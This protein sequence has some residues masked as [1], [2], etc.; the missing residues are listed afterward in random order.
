MILLACVTWGLVQNLRASDQIRA[1]VLLQWFEGF[2]VSFTEHKTIRIDC[3]KL[4]SQSEN[5]KKTQWSIIQRQKNS[6]LSANPE[7]FPCGYGA[8]FRWGHSD[9]LCLDLLC[10]CIRVGKWRHKISP[11]SA[12][13][14]N[15]HITAFLMRCWKDDVLLWY[16]ALLW[17]A[18]EE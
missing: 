4:Q 3:L 1:A 10:L 9:L 12:S 13:I 18:V 2:A 15:S 14:H 16:Q 7:L 6:T 8:L 5:P 17:E 11:I